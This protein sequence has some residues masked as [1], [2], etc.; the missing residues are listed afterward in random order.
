MCGEWDRDWVK[1]RGKMKEVFFYPSIDPEAGLIAVTCWDRP[2][3]QGLRLK[4]WLLTSVCVNVIKEKWM[5]G[6]VKS[7]YYDLRT[8]L[9]SVIIK[10]IAQN[11]NHVW[12][13]M[14]IAM[15]L[16]AELHFTGDMLERPSVEP[17]M[18]V[19]TSLNGENALTLMCAHVGVCVYMQKRALSHWIN[20]ALMYLEAVSC[21][22]HSWAED[23]SESLCV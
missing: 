12:L 14:H 11:Y 5:S 3:S 7:I 19:P 9:F 1:V 2:P 15:A 10:I 18:L 13:C 16:R 8:F 6:L 17:I 21:C 4:V 22:F 20:G 23:S